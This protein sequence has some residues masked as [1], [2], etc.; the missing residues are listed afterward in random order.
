MVTH[1]LAMNS[2]IYSY[3]PFESHCALGHRV[4][5]PYNST[6]TVSEKKMVNGLPL[7]NFLPFT[8]D[9]PYRNLVPTVE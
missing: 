9:S 6:G 4:F 3:P 8:P 5:F 2:A 1:I 7:V